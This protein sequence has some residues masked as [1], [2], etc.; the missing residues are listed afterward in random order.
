MHAHVGGRVAAA[1]VTV[2]IGLAPAGCCFGGGEDASGGGGGAEGDGGPT[3]TQIAASLSHACAV[4]S[5]GLLQCW[6]QNGFGELGNG[7]TTASPTAGVIVR[8]L[9]DVVEVDVTLGAT[10]ARTRAGRIYCWGRPSSLVLG[11]E[12]AND[13]RTPVRVPGIE[14]ALDL[15]VAA[16]RAAA[17]L[18]D[19]TVVGWGRNE[20][21]G[22]GWPDWV[23]SAAQPMGVAIVPGAANVAVSNA[24][25]AIR[26]ATGELTNVGLTPVCNVPA[27]GVE[28]VTA[29]AHGCYQG[30]SAMS[31]AP[32]PRPGART[33]VAQGRAT[34]SIGADGTVA[35]AGECVLAA[36]PPTLGAVDEVAPGE[37]YH[38]ARAGTRVTCWGEQMENIGATAWSGTSEITFASGPAPAA[39]AA[40]PEPIAVPGLA[41]PGIREHTAPTEP[42]DDIAVEATTPL[43][44]GEIIAARTHNNDGYYQ[45]RVQALLP[46]GS[47]SV[48]Y[49]RPQR[50]TLTR[51]RLRLGRWTPVPAGLRSY[52]GPRLPDTPVAP[53][54]LIRL[55]DS[56]WW[57]QGVVVSDDG[58]TLRV[59]HSGFPEPDRQ[60]VSR[61]SLRLAQ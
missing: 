58:A 51:D 4:M 28:A 45:A 13:A 52:D 25:V 2:G 57:Y 21:G 15:D 35:C 26:T 1:A 7:T 11:S 41:W 38:C 50:E 54:T 49:E 48:M 33:L 8:G 37:T 9:T 14:G 31:P 59:R 42:I 23:A 19:G 39:P 40:E 22:F 43:Q 44:I 27:R 56:G 55:R 12:R 3:P 10:C 18:P 29:S 47:V 16:T 30:P 34:W 36:I 61:G 5:D 17:V 6:G 24:G 53:G 32:V 60:P 20:F 46:D